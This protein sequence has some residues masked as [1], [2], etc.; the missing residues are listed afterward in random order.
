MPEN[1]APPATVPARKSTP[2]AVGP[3]VT[4]SLTIPAA[5]G[6][7]IAASRIHAGDG[8]APVALIVPAVGVRRRYYQPYAAF[9]ALEGYT[10]LTWDW[11]GIGDSA[12]RSL[13][14]FRATMRQWAESDFTGVIEWTTRAH[15]RSQVV[16]VGHSFG[17]QALGLVRNGHRLTAAVT[18]ASPSGYLGHWPLGTRLHHA[19]LWYV[20]VPAIT[21]ALGYFP[22]RRLGFGEDL[23]KGVALQW[24][25][26]CRSP[27]YLGDWSG[28]RR[29]QVPILAFSFADDAYA[30]LAAVE[31]LHREFGTREIRRRHVTPSEVG[32]ASIGHF[33]FFRGGAAGSLWQETADWLDAT[34]ETAAHR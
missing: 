31:A 23:P 30:P 24:A 4:E 33:G 16:A 28:H 14:G 9:L 17:G 25:E 22:A 21:H 20:G 13:R 5:D 2:G 7:P 34:L 1:S 10:V 12:P 29:F 32:A 11:R 3:Y 8:T 18:V 19:A 15:P 26:W 27:S 6:F